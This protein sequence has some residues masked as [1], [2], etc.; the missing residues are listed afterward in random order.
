MS[1]QISTITAAQVTFALDISVFLVID[2]DF[3]KSWEEQR[4]IA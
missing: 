4:Q 2:I 1:D 3:S